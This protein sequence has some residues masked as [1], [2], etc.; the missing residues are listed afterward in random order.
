M[1]GSVRRQRPGAQ[2]DVLLP[3]LCQE[4]R[5]LQGSP[6]CEVVKEALRITADPKKTSKLFYPVK[7]RPHAYEPDEG[8]A[9]LIRE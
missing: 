4:R 1:K 5:C 2:R 7:F 6:A 8:D 3:T 9:L